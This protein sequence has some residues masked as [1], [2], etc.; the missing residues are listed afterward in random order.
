MGRSAEQEK[1]AVLSREKI[2]IELSQGLDFGEVPLPLTSMEN[3]ELLEDP[4]TRDVR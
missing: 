4:G 3:V 1:S 2:S